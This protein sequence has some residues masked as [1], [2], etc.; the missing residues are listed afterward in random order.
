MQ[1]YCN[2]M[3]SR[4]EST[5]WN[6]VLFLALALNRGMHRDVPLPR[7]LPPLGK[8]AHRLTP[9]P[10][11]WQTPSGFTP[12]FPNESPSAQHTWQSMNFVKGRRGFSRACMYMY[13]IHICW[14]RWSYCFCSGSDLSRNQCPVPYYFVCYYVWIHFISV[15][16]LNS[17]VPIISSYASPLGYPSGH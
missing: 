16:D 7:W 4:F 8:S 2:Y 3:T 14:P 11:P 9:W 12:R 13:T 10:V 5:W 17:T 1:I 15:W 6:Y